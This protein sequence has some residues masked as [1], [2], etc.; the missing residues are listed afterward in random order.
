VVEEEPPALERE[1]GLRQE[2]LEDAWKEILRAQR[3]A[4]N[5]MVQEKAISGEVYEALA[6]E[7]DESLVAPD[8]GIS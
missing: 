3:S 7:V 2:A 5:R 1:P 6:K 4:L 8:S